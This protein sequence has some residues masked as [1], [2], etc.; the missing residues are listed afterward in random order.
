[1]ASEKTNFPATIILDLDY[2]GSGS[3]VTSLEHR[4]IFVSES[5]LFAYYTPPPPPPCSPKPCQAPGIEFLCLFSALS[6]AFSGRGST[7]ELVLFPPP[8]RGVFS[9]APLVWNHV[10][11]KG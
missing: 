10:P 3:G 2:Q 6:F 4:T 5:A 7:A 11:I 1:M 9:P 8:Y